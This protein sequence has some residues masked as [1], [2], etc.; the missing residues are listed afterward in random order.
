MHGRFENVTEKI[1]SLPDSLIEIET[2]VFLRFESESG[3]PLI[4]ATLCLLE[5]SK[6]GLLE[7]ELLQLLNETLEV[8]SS[9][10]EQAGNQQH[11]AVERTGNMLPAREWAVVYRNL[12]PFLRPCG[13]LG[14]GRLDFYHRYI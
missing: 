11:A 7:T 10:E 12:K 1:E 3:G 5:V 2:E 13:D 8:P 6:H 4:K 9:D 14:E